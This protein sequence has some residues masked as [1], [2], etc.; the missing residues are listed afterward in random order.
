MATKMTR[1]QFMAAAGGSVVGIG[2]PG[3][4]RTLTAQEDHALIRARRPDGRL[5]IPPGQ[6][7]VAA[8]QDMGGTPGVADTAGFQLR[9]Y[10][11]VDRPV[12]LTLDRLNALGRVE[13]TCDV[14]CVT[15]WTLLEARWGGIPL[16]TLM[17]LAAVR[18]EAGF[19]IFES[20]GEYTAN[21]PLAEARKA[22]VILADRFQGNPLPLDHG[23]PFR[24]LVPDLYF[25]KS[26]K[27]VQGIRFAAEDEPGYY[28]SRGYSNSADPWT[29][30]RFSGD[31]GRGR[32]KVR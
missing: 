8:L 10:G 30:E 6:R 21:I 2:L 32:G 20:P 12:T 19:V 9:L 16:T 5:R 22:N 23:A 25:W 31:Q 13:I 29:E 1:R 18:E 4:F 24:A 26:A 7:A 15:G 11:A 17:E 14:H 3:T 28:E 27:W